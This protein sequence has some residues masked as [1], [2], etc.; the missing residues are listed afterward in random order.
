MA[1]IAAA[2]MWAVTVLV[3]CLLAPAVSA[4][5]GQFTATVFATGASVSASQPDSITVAG[6]HVFIEY[7][8]GASS[9]LP[10]GTGGA[11]TIAEGSSFRRS[12]PALK[13]EAGKA[14]C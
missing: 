4:R 7:S 12:A 9:T 2:S 5:G 10:P 14:A 1:R 11:S 13:I 6:G 3:A 8:N